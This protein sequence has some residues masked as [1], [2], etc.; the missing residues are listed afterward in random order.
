MSLIN[1]GSHNPIERRMNQMLDRFW[2]SGF[3]VGQS[4]HLNPAVEVIENEQQFNVHAELPGVHKEDIQVDV[5][6][7][8]LTFSAESKSSTEETRDN[9]RYSERRYGTYSRTIPVPDTVDKEHI[10]ANFKD[11]VLDISMPKTR[12]KKHSTK[13]INVQ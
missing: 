12:A 4:G 2:D 3:D 9:V 11:G 10:Q 6:D 5:G 1:W 8:S 13:K 7:H